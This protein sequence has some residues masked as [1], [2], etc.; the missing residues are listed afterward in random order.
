MEESEK[1]DIGAIQR[2]D[3]FQR[4]LK[5][6][7]WLYSRSK[8]IRGSQLVFTVITPI[9]LAILSTVFSDKSQSTAGLKGWAAFYGI[10]VSLLDIAVLEKAQA[11]FKNCAAKVQ[12]I[13]DCKLLVLPWNDFKVGDAP[14]PEDIDQWARSRKHEL[15]ENQKNWYPPSAGTLPLYLSR[16]VC[17]RSNLWW[18][19]ELRHRF[20]QLLVGFTAFLGT[21]ALVVGF[22]REMTLS[23]FVLS[24][25]APLS[26]ALIW[27]IKEAKK[28]QETSHN[29]DRLMTQAA[30]LWKSAFDQTSNQSDLVTRSRELQD[31]I[32][33][34]RRSNQPIPNWFNRLF[35]SSL[36][37]S[38]N[39][40]AEDLVSEAKNLLKK[41]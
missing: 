11:T 1:R 39:Q 21:V 13:F 19:R 35:S 12:E 14:S 20:I 41:D 3:F 36:D 34:H 9:I 25:M 10:A 17:Q 6:S 18:D 23:V 26:P 31:E 16:I 4:N 32:Y 8:L 38:L 27:F 29:L 22:V 5:A 30:R 40:G 24:I 37:T 33:I 28:Q 15:T 2:S 7:S